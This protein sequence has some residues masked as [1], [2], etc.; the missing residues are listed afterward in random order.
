MAAVSLRETVLAAR[1]RA[2]AS[3]GARRAP[4]HLAAAGLSSRDVRTRLH[5]SS[6]AI[7]EAGGPDTRRLR[8]G[9]ERL[10]LALIAS[11]RAAGAFARLVGDDKSGSKRNGRLIAR[12]H[13]LIRGQIEQR[14]AGILRTPFVPAAV[15]RLVVD[16]VRADEAERCP[17]PW[18][19][20]AGWRS[21]DWD[22][23]G[24]G[25]VEIDGVVLPRLLMSDLAAA[26]DVAC[27]TLRHFRAAKKIDQIS[28]FSIHF[29]CQEGR[30][31]QNAFRFCAGKRPRRRR[32]DRRGEAG[33]I[34]G[35]QDHPQGLGVSTPSIRGSRRI[36]FPHGAPCFEPSNHA[37]RL[38]LTNAR[39]VAVDRRRSSC[40]RGFDR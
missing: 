18:P 2:K 24:L 12:G 27:A 6:V 9:Q 1:W 39:P 28:G 13:P 4:H 20:C 37:W 8:C 35:N 40:M 21:A 25:G 23:G 36:A 33:S 14:G 32:A 10:A 29:T 11:V 17:A 5:A 16:I 3:A 31:A 30:N 19:D 22:F 34:V 15:I 38:P 26:A 7:G